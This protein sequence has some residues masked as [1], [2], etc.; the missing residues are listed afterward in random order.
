MPLPDYCF[1]FHT[2]TP[3]CVTLFCFVLFN[4]CRIELVQL[5]VIKLIQEM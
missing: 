3:K 5:V 4:Y 2:E 1:Y